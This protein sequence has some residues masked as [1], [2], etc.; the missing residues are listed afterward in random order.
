M[1]TVFLS[2][3]SNAGNRRLYIEKMVLKLSLVVGPGMRR[4]VLMETEPVGM[5]RGQRW[6]LNVI[7][8]AEYRGSVQELL[9]ECVRIEKELGRTGKMS[10]AARTADI[11]I[12]LFGRAMFREPSLTV[13]HPRILDRRFCLEGLRQVGACWKLPGSGLTFTEQ[14]RRMPQRVAGQKII[15]MPGKTPGRGQGQGQS[16]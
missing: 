12:L 9:A 4:S 6:F 10:M 5:S 1:A 11:D 15:F 8:R 3:G 13:P 16:R 2:L 7:V 14:W